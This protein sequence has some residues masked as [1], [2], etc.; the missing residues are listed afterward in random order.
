M[1]ESSNVILVTGGNRGIGLETVKLL[2][3]NLG[4]TVV[5][6]FN[7]TEPADD[8]FNSVNV[9][10]LKCDV[11]DGNQLDSLFTNIKENFGQILNVVCCAGIT[12]DQLILRHKDED[13]K[14]VIDSNLNSAY[15]TVRRAIPAMIKS[16]FGRIVFVSSVV[17]FMGSPGQVSYSAS[18]SAML[19]MARSI[20]REVSNRNITANVI[21]PG[22]I[23]TDMLRSAGEK[24]IDDMKSLIPLG[25][26][27]QPKEVAEVISFLVS[28]KGSYV[29]GALITVDGGLSMGY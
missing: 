4:N 15:M 3:E 19:G 28:P 23:D 16:R 9:A 7:S 1:D 6:T 24:R 10:A 22:A 17:G 21:A 18:K 8:V 26:I 14:K 25:R 5:S 20:A 11:T 12:K 29:N 13:F 27:G 2:S